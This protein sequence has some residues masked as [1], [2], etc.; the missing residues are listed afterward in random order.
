MSRR[1][2]STL[3]LVVGIGSEDRS[4]DRIGLE[5]AR[6]LGRDPRLQADVIVYPGELTGLLDLWAGRAL[7]VVVDAVRSAR[8][9]GTVVR[10]ECDAGSPPPRDAA[11]SS[12]T[13]SLGAVIELGRAV[14]ALPVR[15]VVFGLE[16]ERFDLGQ[17]L[18]PAVRSGRE[19]LLQGVREEI[20]RYE[21]G[22]GGPRH[23]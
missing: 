9:A 11:V 17:E 14:G 16:G 15:L 20:A 23:A 18:S 5:V 8:P 6:E 3:P 4:D 22:L 10:W 2:S 1:P 13:V 19:Q 12:H 7:A 21:T